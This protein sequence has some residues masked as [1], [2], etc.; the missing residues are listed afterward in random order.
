[1]TY[2]RIVSIAIAVMLFTIGVFAQHTLRATKYY[3][4]H[5]CGIVT[6]DGSR[7]NV[8]KV[9]SGEHRWVA[10]S[11][12]MFRKGYKFGDRIFVTSKNPRL[13]G[14]WVVKD[15]MGL[16]KRNSIDFLMTVGNSKKFVN[17]CNVTIRKI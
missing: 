4:R 6:A 13:S 7:I 5:N 16:R 10:L 1:M 15:K 2:K 9:H 14:I 8:D 3:P 12:D 11:R 17:P